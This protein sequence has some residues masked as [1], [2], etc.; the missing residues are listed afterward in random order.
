MKADLECFPCFL[1]Q[2]VMALSYTNLEEREKIEIVRA[3]MD[4]VRDADLNE[5][6]AYATSFIY[7]TISKLSGLD[8]YAGIKKK[9]NSDALTLYPLLRKRVLD[10]PDPLWAASRLAMAGNIIDFGIF[11]SVDVESAIERAMRPSIEVDDYRS[12]ASDVG[13]SKEILY[14]LDNAGEIVLDRLLIEVLTEMGK[15][16]TAVVKGS[17]VIN[18][19]T[20]EDAEQAGIGTICRVIDNGTDAVGTILKFCGPPFLDEYLRHDLIVSK[21][22][23][24]YETLAGK[25]KNIYFLF[26]AKCDVVSRDLGLELGAMLLKK[27]IPEGV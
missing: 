19:A 25:D 6:P 17:P 22:Q 20:M 11:K 27:N 23:G 1:R 24:N 16:I 5:P 10:C 4:D 21:G 13:G 2:T 3:V 14:L 9:C 7:R 8:P 12:F 15:T 18:D 26:Q